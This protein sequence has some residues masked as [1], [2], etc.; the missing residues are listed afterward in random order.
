[1]RRGARIFV[2]I[3]LA[4]V[5]VAIWVTAVAVLLLAVLLAHG[6]H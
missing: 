3:V 6:W 4:A 2:L 5:G 1:M